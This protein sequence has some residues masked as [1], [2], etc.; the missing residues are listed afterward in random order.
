M[1][2][3]AGE[4]VDDT[5]FADIA[6]PICLIPSSTAFAALNEQEQLCTYHMYRAAFYGTRIVL[7]QNSQESETIY[8]CSW[9]CARLLRET[10]KS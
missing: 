9:R 3:M 2:V 7:R 4:F 5:L 8:T 6:V 10:G 1:P